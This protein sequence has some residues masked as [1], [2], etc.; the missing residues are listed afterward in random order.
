MPKLTL[1]A[2]KRAA[3]GRG[4][5][6][7]HDTYTSPLPVAVVSRNSASHPADGDSS[8]KKRHAPSGS[9]ASGNGTPASRMTV[10]DVS[11][12]STDAGTS[13]PAASPPSAAPGVYTA[14][15]YVEPFVKNGDV[16]GTATDAPKPL[17]PGPP[18]SPAQW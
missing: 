2:S 13:A 7:V 6:G 10:V 17:P 1:R 5:A 3:V 8:T 9:A 18:D 14:I 12:T 11:A 15:E 4:F 16:A